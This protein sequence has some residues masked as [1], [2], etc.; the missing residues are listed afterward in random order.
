MARAADE[1]IALDEPL[2]RS[3]KNHKVDNALARRL[4]IIK[5]PE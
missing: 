2:Y 4:R 1:E 3:I 5:M